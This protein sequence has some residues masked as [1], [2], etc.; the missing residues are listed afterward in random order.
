MKWVTREHVHVDRMACPWLI[1]RFIDAS[2]EF[3]FVPAADVDRTVKAE[4]ATPFDVPGCEFGHHEEFC[5]FDAIMYKHKLQ[6]EALFDLAAIV[7]AADTEDFEAAP[8]A[9]G[10]RA[11]T[12]GASMTAKD[13]HEAVD[14]G[15]YIFDALYAH[16]KLRHLRERHAVELEPMDRAAQTAF[17]KERLHRRGMD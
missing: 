14:K 2:A 9:I 6:D 17:L 7:R 5:S 10:L 15:M 4:G 12:W 16:C 3:M 13:D 11:I 8:E 1:R